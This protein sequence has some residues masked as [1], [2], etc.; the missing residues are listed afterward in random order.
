M[1]EQL[2]RL[3][4][5]LRAGDPD[6]AHTLV[7]VVADHGE[8]LAEDGRLEHGDSLTDTVQHV[9]WI[10]AGAGIRPGQVVQHLTENIDVVPTLLERLGVPLPEGTWVD[11]RAQLEADG[12]ACPSCGKLAAFYAWESYRAIRARRHLLR[13]NLPGSPRARMAR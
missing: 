13:E 2:G 6:L 11:G 3:F 5:A 9:P 12:S 8:E 10:M 4:A 1:D 7:L